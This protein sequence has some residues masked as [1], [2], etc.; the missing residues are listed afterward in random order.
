MTVASL[1]VPLLP[2]GTQ[3]ADRINDLDLTVARWFSVG[4]R[5]RLQ[6][7]AAVF[8]VLNRSPAYAVRSLN[9]TTTSYLQ[10]ASVLQGRYLRI[11]MQAR[12]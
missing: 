12:W 10:P 6:P 8:N 7:E 9:Y 3:F 11:G 2:P 1:A 4:S 5:L